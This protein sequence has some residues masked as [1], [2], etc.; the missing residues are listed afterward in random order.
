MTNT[1]AQL[2][3]F[4]VVCLVKIGIYKNTECPL[5]DTFGLANCKCPGI[6]YMTRTTDHKL[7]EIDTDKD[8]IRS[9]KTH[10]CDR[11]GIRG[12]NMHFSAGYQGDQCLICAGNGTNVNL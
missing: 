12:T 3:Y 10:Q 9:N 6:K 5:Y 2:P 8:K 11:I 4:P 7:E 1:Q